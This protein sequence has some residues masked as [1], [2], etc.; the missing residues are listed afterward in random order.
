LW[1]E[2]GDEQ[3]NTRSF[4][5]WPGGLIKFGYRGPDDEALARPLLVRC[6][7]VLDCELVQF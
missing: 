4:V 1:L 6:A 2:F 5:L 7:A 3:D